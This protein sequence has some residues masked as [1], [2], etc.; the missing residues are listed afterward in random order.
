M[1]IQRSSKRPTE[2]EWS[3]YYNEILQA[4]NAHICSHADEAEKENGIHPHK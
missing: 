4:S 2:E 1:A 3:T